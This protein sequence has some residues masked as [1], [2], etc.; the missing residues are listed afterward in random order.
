[1]DLTGGETDLFDN[2]DDGTTD[3]WPEPNG[4]ADDDINYEL[5]SDGQLQRKVGTNPGS[6]IARGID[7]VAFE[8]LNENGGITSTLDLIRSVKIQLT[9]SLP[10]TPMI[11]GD[12]KDMSIASEVKCRNLGTN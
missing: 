7:S 1:M 8:Y 2:D 3:E 6:T 9:A 10:T 5:Q 4:A 12:G 11:N